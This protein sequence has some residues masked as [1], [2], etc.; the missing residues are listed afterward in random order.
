VQGGRGETHK[1]QKVSAAAGHGA[2]VQLRA[3]GGACSPHQLHLLDPAGAC[4]PLWHHT[5]TSCCVSG[6]P[7]LALPGISTTHERDPHPLFV[8]PPCPPLPSP[9][10]NPLKAVCQQ[11]SSRPALLT[12]NVSPLRGLIWPYCLLKPGSRPRVLKDTSLIRVP[13]S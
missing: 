7:C 13:S 1:R 3:A 5:Q 12:R 11:S 4:R 9:L 8:S 2:E 6:Q 10:Q